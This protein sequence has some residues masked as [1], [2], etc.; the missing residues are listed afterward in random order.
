MKTDKESIVSA[1]R[2]WFQTDDVFEIRVLDAVSTEWMRPHMESGYFDYEH[3]P[4]AAE[5][6]G[7][8][9][10]YRGAY[11]T[12]NP[13]NPDL[14]ARACNRLRGITREATTAD[15]DIVT[16]RWLLVDCD[17]KRVSGVSSS[18]PEHE[19]AISMACKIR[20]GLSASGWPDPI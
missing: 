5:A 18:D 13:V 17:P 1:L 6:I 2:L 14:L 9:R 16:R 20:S 15:A 11:A 12:V 3:I 8:L 10:S 7:K 19:A 4:D